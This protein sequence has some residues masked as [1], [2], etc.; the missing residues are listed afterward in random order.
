MSYFNKQG[1][2][3]PSQQEAIKKKPLPNN[4]KQFQQQPLK[5]QQEDPQE[6]EMLKFTNDEIVFIENVL[7]KLEDMI[8]N[9]QGEGQE[10]LEMIVTCQQIISAR[11]DAEAGFIGDSA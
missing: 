2:K 10:I 8:P 11:L 5:Q 1:S 7:V 4:N 3:R 9:D 6:S